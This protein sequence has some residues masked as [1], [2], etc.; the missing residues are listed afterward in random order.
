MVI[1][2]GTR[3]F[4]SPR[5]SRG[6]NAADLRSRFFT[7]HIQINDLGVGGAAGEAAFFGGELEGFFAVE[8]GLVHQLFDA[9]GQRLGRVGVGADFVGVGGTDE[10]RDFA[11]SG[12]FFQGGGDFRKFSAEKFF[13]ELGDFAGEAGGAVAEDFAGVGDG[14]SDAVRGFI[15]DESAVLDAEAFESAA[16]LAAASRKKADK[17]EFF[18][19]KAR[20]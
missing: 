13:V 12:A 19:G 17:E 2:R 10:Q 20:G 7:I 4:L 16:A 3:S 1:W 6:G 14:F 5:D 9:G 8:L 11:A 18:V 15:E